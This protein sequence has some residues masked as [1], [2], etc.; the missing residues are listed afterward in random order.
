MPEIDFENEVVTG[1]TPRL[2]Q[3]RG[4]WH[5]D[6]GFVHGEVE[7][8]EDGVLVITDW[9]SP[10]RL[11]GNTVRALNWLRSEGY[12]TIRVEQVV[13]NA[14]AYW[15]KMRERGLVND[16]YLENGDELLLPSVARKN[17]GIPSL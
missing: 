14:Q 17:H 5:Y 7:L 6:D 8:P 12:H 16:L 2:Y 9:F 3:E 13:E 11:A 4:Y 15:L 10:H 1:F